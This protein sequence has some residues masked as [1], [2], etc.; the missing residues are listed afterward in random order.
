[1]SGVAFTMDKSAFSARISDVNG[2]YE[3]R[4]NPLSKVGVFPYLGAQLPG[5]SDPSR[6]YSVFRPEAELADP[7]FLASLRLLPWV[8]DHEMLGDPEAGMTPPEDYGVHGVIGENVRYENGLVLGTIK[9][10][11]R[12]MAAKINNDK[13]ELSLGYRCEYDWTPGVYK[14][15]PYDA[16][17]RR[18]RGNHLALVG[19]GR[20]GPEVAVKD[21]AMD[22]QK[23]TL[24]SLEYI[25]MADENK[26]GGAAN[27]SELTLEQAG[28]MLDK[29]LP[30]ID[31][32]AAL[33]SG[34]PAAGAATA[35][36]PKPDGAA[37]PAAKDPNDPDAKAMTDALQVDM[38]AMAAMDKKITA[39]QTSLAKLAAKP[40]AAADA[41]PV[42]DIIVVG[43]KTYAVVKP[44]AAADAKPQMDPAEFA[45]QVSG[46]LHDR[47]ALVERVRPH[48]GVFDH[49]R[50]T[51]G[52][53]AKYAAD[54]LGLKPAA[55]SEIVAVDAYLH[56]RSAPRAVTNA[57][58]GKSTAGGAVAGYLNPASAAK[59]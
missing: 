5:A 59:P 28:E 4:D 17:Q 40:A 20:M 54:K 58:D 37:V 29:L 2:Y 41:K 26:E 21:A 10:W 38:A 43:G 3:V 31:R 11:S 56:N 44:A 45:R 46:N 36:E 27:P 9:C 25:K 6:V 19:E 15:I 57:T 32:I 49:A 42:D 23:L 13:K 34:A 8:D 18:L 22:H 30:F 51:V 52:E 12:A 33:K 14:G 55:G 47:D 7:E 35:D 24:D 1:M 50:M 53:V 39:L 48:V 16:V